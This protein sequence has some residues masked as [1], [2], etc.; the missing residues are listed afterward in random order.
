ISIAVDIL[1]IKIYYETQN[2]LLDSRMKALDQ[3]IRRATLSQDA[4]ERYYNFLKKLDKLVRYAWTPKHPKRLKLLEEI[5]NT[6]EIVAREWLL[7]KL[8]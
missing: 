6:E 7:E 1:I 5:K 8:R 3:K 4:K 2:A